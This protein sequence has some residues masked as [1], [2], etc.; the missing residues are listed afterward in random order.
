MSFTGYT[1]NKNKK[2]KDWNVTQIWSTQ[3]VREEL[4]YN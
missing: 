2:K 1:N 3:E 4:I